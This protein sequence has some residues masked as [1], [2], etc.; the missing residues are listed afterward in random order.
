MNKKDVIVTVTDIDDG[1]F[2]WAAWNAKRKIYKEKVCKRNIVKFLNND[3]F[4]INYDKFEKDKTL[5]EFTYKEKVYIYAPKANKFRDDK[6]QWETK[7]E[8]LIENYDDYKLTF[9]KFNGFTL[10]EVY[11]K[12]PSYLNW[13]M[14]VDNFKKIHKK[15]N[16]FLKS[17]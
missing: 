16:K 5:I 15:V 7:F 12:E 3:E 4:E 17:K 1:H 6:Y 10:S 9:G 8:D 11:C 14:S 2:D 13:I